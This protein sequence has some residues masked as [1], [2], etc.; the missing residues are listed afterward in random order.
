MSTKPDVQYM[1]Q[2]VNQVLMLKTFV[3]SIKPIW[4]ALAGS[5]SDDLQM[6]HQV[7]MSKPCKRLFSHC[8]CSCADQKTM[9]KSKRLFGKL[10]TRMYTTPPSRQIYATNEFMP[11][12]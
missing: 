8:I 12:E 5:S 3:E 1:E 6:I 4:Q 9:Q 10:S 2:S 7:S 11:Y